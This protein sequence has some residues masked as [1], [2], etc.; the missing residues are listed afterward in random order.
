MMSLD[1]TENLAIDV[2]ASGT[3]EFQ[4]PDF[5]EIPLDI[6]ALI[7]EIEKA[8]DDPNTIFRA[9][10][11]DDEDKPDLAS[12]T[13]ECLAELVS[14][15]RERDGLNVSPA[16][17]TPILASQTF[18]TAQATAPPSYMPSGM[19]I[20]W[21]DPVADISI[22][23][24]RKKDGLVYDFTN[25]KFAP[26]ASITESGI[27][28]MVRPY[29]GTVRNAYQLID[30]P[31]PKE[32]FIDGVYRIFYF[33]AD[34]AL[35]DAAGFGVYLGVPYE[36]PHPPANTIPNT[37]DNAIKL[38][39]SKLSAHND[40]DTPGYALNVLMGKNPPPPHA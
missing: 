28:K 24:V 12:I 23:V 40:P 33:G 10:S 27:K 32:V 14:Q 34:N 38:L 39:H 37:A 31:T 8:K 3:Y 5:F 1:P 4:A 30:M 15:A 7:Q 9:M 21:I 18:L 11:V 2:L 17:L 35:L 16:A 26:E 20:D 22:Q 19:A 13:P 36:S 25:N 6:Q 29:A